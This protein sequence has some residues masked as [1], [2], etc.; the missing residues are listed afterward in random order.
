LIIINELSCEGSLYK[1]IIFKYKFP[2]IV[3]L[4]ELVGEIHAANFE[5]KGKSSQIL[6]KHF[7]KVLSHVISISSTLNAKKFRTNFLT[8]PK[9][10]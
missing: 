1:F 10:N 3:S 8:K 4:P 9:L 7:I 6:S 5:N 2:Y